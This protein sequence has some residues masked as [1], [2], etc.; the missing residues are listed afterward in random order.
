[1]APRGWAHTG[2]A[3]GP[4]VTTSLSHSE[5]RRF[6]SGR[7]H[8]SLGVVPVRSNLHYPLVFEPSAPPVSEL[9]LRRLPKDPMPA[10]Q[11]ATFH[12]VDSIVYRRSHSP[13][14]GVTLSFKGLVAAIIEIGNPDEFASRY[15]SILESVFAEVGLDRLKK[16]YKAYEIAKYL[17]GRPRAADATFYRFGRELLSIDGLTVNV[18]GSNFDVVRLA[19]DLGLKMTGDPAHDFKTLP[20]VGAFGRAPGRK[21]ITLAELVDLIEHPFPA[22]A[23]WKLVENARMR[24]QSFLMDEIGGPISK[25]WESLTESNRVET[26]PHGDTCS[27]FISAADLLLRAIDRQLARDYARLIRP[28][29]EEAIRKIRGTGPGAEVHVHMIGNLDIP[30]IVPQV[31]TTIPTTQF[32][33]HPLFIVVCENRHKDERAELEVSPLFYAVQ[34]RA[35]RERGGVAF[36]NPKVTPSLIRPGDWLVSY[37][38]VGREAYSTLRAM[39][40]SIHHWEAGGGEEEKSSTTPSG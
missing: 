27:P 13:S 30:M 40:Y 28:D 26:I 1:M 37:G 36:Y 38:Q 32:V 18:V 8:P 25:A 14:P 23:S 2:R 29:L 4:A 10:S 22:L 3:R 12:A 15:E 9:R 24:R 35:Y 19:A 34:D 31:E 20:A 5:D 17:S 16:V 21:Y 11:P 33:R 6:E 7:A 39:S